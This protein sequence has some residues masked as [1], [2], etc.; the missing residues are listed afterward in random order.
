M[1]RASSAV[2]VAARRLAT[3][4]FAE[5]QDWLAAWPPHPAAIPANETASPTAARQPRS[6][7]DL[8]DPAGLNS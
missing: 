1:V 6:C 5:A 8:R 3:L 2:A 4:P 7:T